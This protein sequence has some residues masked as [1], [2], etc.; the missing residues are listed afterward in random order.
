MLVKLKLLS[1]GY[2]THREC[3]TI[4][5]GSLKQKKFPAICA[6]IN[7]PQKGYILFDTGYTEKFFEESKGFP[8]S[9]YPKV[10]PVYIQENDTLKKQLKSNGVRPEEISYIF[11]SHFHA[12][13]I[14]GLN[15]F[16]KAKFICSRESYNSVKDLR[17]VKA[18][19][20]GFMKGLVPSD[21]E[22][23][24]L[25]VEDIPISNLQE[26]MSPFHHCYDIF[27]DSSIRAVKLPGHAK[28][29]YGVIVNDE[30]C[31][32]FFLVA[33]SCWSSKAFR[34]YKLPSNI[35][36]LIHDNKSEYKDTLH[37]LHKLHLKNKNIKIIPSHCDEVWG[38]IKAVNDVR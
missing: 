15:D 38:K 21:F 32:R 31:G 18:L 25:F 8:L 11:I 17:G 20:K 33:D 26:D 37:K 6:L 36:Y 29:Q 3:V 14:S 28:G 35:T 34:E 12:D 7:H 5:G 27:S 30:T 9:I 16:S 23:R 1:A 4:Q 19:L 10:T 13:H 24:A 2:C 22:E